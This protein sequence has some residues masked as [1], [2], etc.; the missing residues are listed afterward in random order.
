M[1]LVLTTLATGCATGPTLERRL[2]LTEVSSNEVELYLDE[3]PSQALNL[4]NG[5]QLAVRVDDGTGNPRLT[6]LGLG[7]GDQQ[8]Q[9]GG[10]FMVWEESGYNG[11]PMAAP[12]PSGQQGVVPGIKVAAGFLTGL[13]DHPSEVRLSGSRRR[14]SRLIILIPEQTT[15]V[16]DD[17]VRFGTPVAQRPSSGG[18]FQ[19][20]G[21]LANP[22]G[23]N[24]VQR[25]F[26]GASPVDGDAESDWTRGGTSWGVATP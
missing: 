22:S 6:T 9:G 4:G 17:V 5:F 11:P 2:L 12:Y 26:N 7:A 19:D 10:F 20:D 1:L 23:S 3:D 8:I 18:A 21:S 24:S 16:V 13:R 15:D 14:I 25:R